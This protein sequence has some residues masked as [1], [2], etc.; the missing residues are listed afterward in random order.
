[1]RNTE[2]SNALTHI[3]N[4]VP[5]D[6]IKRSIIKAD[7]ERIVNSKAYPTTYH[8]IDFVLSWLYKEV[9][10]NTLMQ[11]ILNPSPDLD[12]NELI[13]IFF[14]DI[15]RIMNMRVKYDAVVRTLFSKV[16]HSKE[17]PLVLTKLI[18]FNNDWPFVNISH[19][20]FYQIKLRAPDVS[21]VEIV[22]P[23]Y[24]NLKD[25]DVVAKIFG[26]IWVNG[27]LFHEYPPL[28]EWNE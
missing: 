2:K 17:N 12:D 24:E 4:W 11:Y 25:T 14:E 21:L 18:A 28:T 20:Y 16:I 3:L 6:D 8:A 5:R 9:N 15:L 26:D 23:S 7:V 10:D 22:Q 27:P 1:M 13:A 19:D